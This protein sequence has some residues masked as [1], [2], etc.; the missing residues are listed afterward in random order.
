MIYRA[1]WP[2]WVRYDRY[3]MKI[4][5]LTDDR[6]S[7]LRELKDEV[8]QCVYC[9]NGNPHTKIICDLKRKYVFVLAN[10]RPINSENFIWEEFPKIEKITYGLRQSRKELD[11]KLR[12][13]NYRVKHDVTKILGR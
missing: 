13:E 11:E 8:R 4:K 10:H 9:L 2:R 5:R 12:R 3:I 7:R 6:V 1:K